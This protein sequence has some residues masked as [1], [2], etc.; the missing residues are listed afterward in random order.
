MLR[1]RVLTAQGATVSEAA[2]ARVDQDHAYNGFIAQ[3]EAAR[4]DLGMGV[5]PSY[6]L[7]LRTP[8]GA[9]T[10]TIALL[11]RRMLPAVLVGFLL[12]LAASVL[13]A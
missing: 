13:R 9:R 12:V 1:Q 2:F 3:L 10:S 7:L 11:T 8:L 5:E 6:L 4:E